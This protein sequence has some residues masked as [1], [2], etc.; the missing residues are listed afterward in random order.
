M[1]VGF[2]M[3]RGLMMRCSFIMGSKLRRWVLGKSRCHRRGIRWMGEVVF[4]LCERGVVMGTV[5][6]V[7]CS[8]ALF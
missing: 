7:L 6:A 4:G 2:E 1:G 5:G 8:I 3:E